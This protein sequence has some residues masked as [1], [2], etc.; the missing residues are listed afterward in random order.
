[1]PNRLANETSPYLLQHAENPVE[2][3]PWG[4]EALARAKAE[5]KPILLSIGYSACHWCHVMAHESFE[6]DQVAAL[7]NRDFVNVKVDREERPDLDEL[8]MRAV[9][10]FT[11]GHG[12]WPMTVFLTPE[13]KPFFGG[14]YFPPQA[15][16][17]MPSFTQVLGHVQN[18]W[19]TDRAKVEDVT[20]KV[21]GY[22]AS[23][24]RLP[25]AEGALTDDWL[26]RLARSLDKEFD[27]KHAGFGAAPKFPPHGGLAVLLAHWR[28]TDDKRSLAMTTATLDAMAQGGMYDLLGG[29]FARYSVDPAWKVPHFEKMLYDNAQLVPLYTDAWKVTKDPLYARVVRETLG[30]VLRE[31]TEPAGG[32]RS[33]LD[34][35]SEGEEGR[36][37]AWTPTELRSVLG[38]LD[39]MRVSALL[40]VTD[41]G[42]FEHGTSVL[43]MET[44]R[45]R[46]DDETR[47]LI[48]AALPKLYAARERR[49]H[50]GRD[51]K[52]VTAWNALMISAFARAGAAFDEPHW[53]GAAGTAARFL[54][55]ELRVKGRLQRT[56]KDGR[57]HIPGFAD[58]HAFLVNALIDLY[59]ATFDFDWLAEA[60]ALADTTVDLFWD[61]AE[62]GLY[63]TGKDAE[64]L[65][66]RSKHLLGGAEPS[67][68]GVAALAFARLAELSGRADLGEKADTIL[69]AYQALVDRA[70][71][72]LGTE[73]L[74][75]AW[76]TGAT[77][78]I[79]I[80]GGKAEALLATVYTHYLPFAVVAWHPND[81]IPPLLPWLEDK[82]A[83]GGLGTA[84]L[85]EQR[86]CLAPTT[87]P[88]ELALQL[89][90]ANRPRRETGGKLPL[91]VHAPAL[92][93]DPASWL[94]SAPLP[95]DALRGNV[96]VLDFWTYCCINCMHVLPELQKLEDVTVDD[97]V[98]VIGVHAAKFATEREA[99]NVAR[100]VRR[101]HVHHPV[102]LDPTHTVWDA[103]A[104]RSWPTVVVL[105]AAGRI[106]WQKAGE[107][108]HEE[109][110]PIV[111]KLLEEA[112]AAGILASGPAW[113][114]GE[115]AGVRAGL[116]FPGKVHLW[117]DLVGQAHGRDPFGPDARLYISDTGNH[118]IVEASLS[119]GPDGWPVAKRLRAFGGNGP[120]LVDGPG[121]QAAFNAPQG[122]GRSGET[123]WVADTG[124]HALR[125][126]DLGT[127]YVRTVAGT[128]RL[129]R[130]V[131]GNGGE[132]RKLALR[133][134]WDVAI[135]A[136]KDG[137]AE[138]VFV[139]MAGAHQVWVY[140]PQ[141]DQIGPLFGSG[142]EEHVDGAPGEAALAQPS[143]LSLVGRYLF[144][145]DSETS[146]VR[147]FDLKEHRVGTLVGQGLFDF[148]DI[149][150]PPDKA[151]LQHPLGVAAAEGQL[152]VADTFNH[153]IKSVDLRG[154]GIAT[155]CG[156]PGELS[157]PGGL[158]V[159]GD[160]LIVADTNNHRLRVA[161]RGSGEIRTLDLTG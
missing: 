77:Q 80:V 112:R 16:R 3:F 125:R 10:A 74:A 140:L 60:N 6:D 144:F 90:Q 7:M 97:P 153:K 33:S 12:G 50:P 141:Q 81:Q 128:G 52:V 88:A 64:V 75:S 133:S 39:G 65:L 14:T 152:Y 120:T 13:G 95:L 116:C 105:D 117:P 118:R 111:H 148:G 98:V 25:R 156:G 1:M 124:N 94:N 103:Y 55:D 99:A 139:A 47:A 40:G 58:D 30:W 35:D 89:E 110:L 138:A 2:W 96:V 17:G 127:G 83:I 143:G 121:D 44:P 24:A 73:A 86:T 82:S 91:R 19:G 109:L 123:L 68:N 107:A 26:D 28:R 62:G 154:G 159:A 34:A 37:Y 132:P 84:Y 92:P 100:A 106:A 29:G 101:H 27:A 136:D 158:V 32:F 149:D 54:L 160:Y 42:T 145:A 23:A 119:R 129:G 85:C 63:Y 11:G 67:A 108:T 126:I 5:D 72:A 61:A 131:E 22:L 79:G 76:R 49:V 135:S 161:H 146:S 157:E 36:F 56:W 147:V 104:I 20:G 59:E 41:A 45:E 21:G 137:K 69:R 151:R 38:V 150:G 87:D 71:R 66:T 134:P 115:P 70:P 155:L 142:A 53:R 122:I 57:A 9:Q 15:G 130:G 113:R 4:P 51:D 46:L 114:P 78:Q 18:L 93:T 102:V 8:Y 31:M 43:R 48:E